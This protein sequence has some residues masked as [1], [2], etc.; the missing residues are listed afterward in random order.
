MREKVVQKVMA[1]HKLPWH[2]AE[3]VVD[4]AGAVDEA[5]LQAV[6]LGIEWGKAPAASGDPGLVR[7]L[8]DKYWEAAASRNVHAMLALK[9]SIHK[10]GGV[11]MP[12]K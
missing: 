7:A 8:S 6:K 9:N 2:I 4:G 10:I 11:L 1:E 5:K 3:A 12:K